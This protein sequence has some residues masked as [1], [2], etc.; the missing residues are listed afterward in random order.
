MRILSI[1][2]SL[3]ED[4]TTLKLAN[5]ITAAATSAAD[6]AGLSPETESVNVRNLSSDLTD[7]AL[8]G[9]RSE[10]LEAAFAQVAEADVIVTVAPVYK[11]APVGLH[12][13]FWQL[14]DEKALANKPVLIGSTG[15]T[16]RHSLAGETVLRPMLSYL[17]GI[18]VPTTV[19]AATDDWGSVEGG[20]SLGARIAQASAELIGLAASLNSVAAAPHAGAEASS[21]TTGEFG[22]AGTRRNPSIDDEFN[23]EFITPFAQLL[24]G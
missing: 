21:A 20:R 13:L 23:P 3:S 6:D 24:E 16:P 2:T 12:T 22:R 9:F 5:K 15:G 18:V 14:I 17:K 19:F 7:M 8:T 11:V 1:T 10:N 4:S